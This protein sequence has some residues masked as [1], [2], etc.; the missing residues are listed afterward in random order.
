MELG[1]LAAA[2]G[3]D[4]TQAGAHHDAALTAAV[5]S[6]QPAALAVALEGIGASVAS[7]HPADA[8]ALLGAADTLWHSTASGAPPPVRADLAD[9][10]AAITQTL[11]AASYRQAFRRGAGLTE[12][13]AVALAR[14]LRRL[15]PR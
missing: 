15:E 12:V 13:A 2:S 11:G 9:T 10:A 6:R 8:A 3:E 7:R 5:E 1:Y 14:R 4:P